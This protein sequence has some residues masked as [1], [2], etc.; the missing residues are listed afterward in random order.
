MS[1]VF[2]RST[3][4]LE[5][6]SVQNKVWNVGFG[7]E[8]DHMKLDKHNMLINISLKARIVYFFLSVYF[9]VQA[10]DYTEQRLVYIY[11]SA[12][13]DQT[14]NPTGPRTKTRL[15]TGLGFFGFLIQQHGNLAIIYRVRVEIRWFRLS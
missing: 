11:T 3:L 7:P 15:W 10:Y 6:I 1:S 4:P 2:C 14:P 12:Q 5:C 9:T 13:P 8:I